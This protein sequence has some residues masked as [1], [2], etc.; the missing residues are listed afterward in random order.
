MRLNQYTKQ[1][2]F[3]EDLDE[4]KYSLPLIH[5]LGCREGRVAPAV[6]ADQ[7][8]LLHNMLSQ[9]HVAGRMS[10]DQKK[11]FLEQLKLRGSLEYTRDTINILLEEMRGLAG[12]LGLLQNEMLTGLLDSLRV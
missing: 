12:Q 4:G 1:K 8:I 6:T 3:Y 10:L 2:G 9:R 7:A 5:A 11:L